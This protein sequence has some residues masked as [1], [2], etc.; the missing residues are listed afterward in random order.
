[1]SDDPNNTNANTAFAQGN[2]TQ[3]NPF[4]GDLKGEFSSDFG[5]NTNAVSQIFKSSGFNSEN[6]TRTLLMVLLAVVILGAGVYFFTGG[7]DDIDTFAT[8][9]SEDGEELGEEDEEGEGEEEVEGEGEEELA[10][11]GEEE[12]ALDEEGEEEATEELAE[13]GEASEEE[14]AEGEAEMDSGVASSGS[15]Q[16][17]A[18]NTGD[19]TAYDETRGPAMFSWEG[20]GDRIVFSR[21]PNMTPVVKSVRLNGKS[22]YSFENPYPGTWYWMVE[23]ADGAS[24]VRQFFV[25]SP[26]KRSF[27]V[28]QPAPG[29][30]LAGSGGVISWQ[31][32][33][34]VARYSVELVQSGASWAMPAHRFGTSGTSIALEGVTPGAYDVRV[35]AF[36]EVAGRWEWQ[37]IKGISVQ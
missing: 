21:S 29:G 34:K 22:S 10:E 31:A 20:A 16:L 25:N 19:Q 14:F 24:E 37:V 4:T 2:N 36:S 7:D 15:I 27:P 18:P 13:E 1:M 9:E 32:G 28:T 35:G 26:E 8:G 23:N 33:Q 6:K 30:A 5:T 3:T 11:E 17:I 12:E